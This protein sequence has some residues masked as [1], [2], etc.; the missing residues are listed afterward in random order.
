MQQGLQVVYDFFLGAEPD[1][2]LNPTANAIYYGSKMILG[3][4]V[5]TSIISLF[6]WVK[7]YIFK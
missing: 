3:L 7:G 1:I 5:F 2:L 6:G 4:F